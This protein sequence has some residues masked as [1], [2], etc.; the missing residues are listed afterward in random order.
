MSTLRLNVIW[1][2]MLFPVLAGAV[3]AQAQVIRPGIDRPI[4][5]GMFKGMGSGTNS[6]HTNVHTSHTVMAGMLANPLTANL[7]PDLVIPPAGFIFY[8]MPVALNNGTECASNGCG[9]TPEQLLMIV[10]SLDTLDVLVMSSTTAIGSRITDPAQRLAFETFWETK[11]YVSIHATTD[12]K[13]RWPKQDSV[14]GTQF[15]NHPAEQVATIRRDSAH[16]GDSAWQYLNRGLFS[17]GTDTSFLEEWFF[18]TDSGAGIRAKPYLKPTVKLVEAGMT[19]ITSL[20]MGDHPTSWYRQFPTGGRTFYTGLGH[21]ANVWRDTRTFRRQIYNAIL[22]AAKYDSLST[23]S[24]NPGNKALRESAARDHSRLS[25]S[26]GILIVTVIPEGVHTV[27]LIGIDGRRVALQK[28]EGREMAY[29]FA[30]L[31]S[32]VYVVGVTTSEG[33]SQRLVTVR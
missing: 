4:R 3:T 31:R 12:S 26:P 25:V 2:G 14:H 30:G 20:A 24:I 18:Y 21:R 27:E 8:S 19:G 13:G 10:G 6:W 11:G 22:W 9:P 28:G 29:N 23:V 15:N 16:Q 1:A 7:G 17:N 32:G 33:H 5:V